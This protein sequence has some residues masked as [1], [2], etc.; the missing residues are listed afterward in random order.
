MSALT[1]PEAAPA[2]AGA[3]TLLFYIVNFY[4]FFYNW[5]FGKIY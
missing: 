2:L 5:L 4:K 1:T 3:L